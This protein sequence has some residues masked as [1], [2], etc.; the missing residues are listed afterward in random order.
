[1]SRCLLWALVTREGMVAWAARDGSWHEALDDELHRTAEYSGRS[2][3]ICGSTV[4]IGQT[5]RECK[6][7]GKN[8]RGG[9]NE[10]RG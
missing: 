6:Q 3:A 5:V 1:M 10:T 2:R 9:Q 8:R 4:A 7:L